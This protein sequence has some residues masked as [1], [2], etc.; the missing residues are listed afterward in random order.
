MRIRGKLA[1]VSFKMF[2]STS[3][4]TIIVHGTGGA[5]NRSALR[6]RKT[7]DLE[8]RLGGCLLPWD[9]INHSLLLDERLV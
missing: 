7:A 5:S 4:R 6:Y 9:S 3:G 8:K 1:R 2:L